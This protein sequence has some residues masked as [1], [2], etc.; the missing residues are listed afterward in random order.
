MMDLNYGELM[1]NGRVFVHD[2][3]RVQIKNQVKLNLKIFFIIP[4]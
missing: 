2:I 3:N 1:S 4:I